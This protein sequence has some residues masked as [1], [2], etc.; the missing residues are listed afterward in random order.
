MN[1]LDCLVDGFV[2]IQNKLEGNEPAESFYERVK[3]MTLEEMK[4]FVYWVYTNGNNDGKDG[5]QDDES[6]YFGGYMLELPAED[7]IAT[8]NFL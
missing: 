3:R 5:L 2:E 7:V 8:G 4:A 1:F 6:G